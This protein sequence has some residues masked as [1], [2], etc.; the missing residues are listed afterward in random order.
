MIEYLPCLGTNLL[1]RAQQIG[2]ADAKAWAQLHR[3]S[4]NEQ[5]AVYVVSDLW[6]QREED[7]G[8]ELGR[9]TDAVV[10]VGAVL[11]EIECG[12][13][14]E[15]IPQAFGQDHLGVSEGGI[16]WRPACGSEIK[17]GHEKRDGG[18]VGAKRGMTYAMLQIWLI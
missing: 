18:E 6:G 1:V 4:M 8:P 7:E 5:V 14:H 2:I 15:Q 9:V 17:F 16:S 10:V 12:G 13:F 3:F 11:A